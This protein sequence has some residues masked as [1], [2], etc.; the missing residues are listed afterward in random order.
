MRTTDARMSP[1]R[2]LALAPRKPISSFSTSTGTSFN[3]LSDEYPLPKSS[4]STTNPAARSFVTAPI[5][6]SGASMYALSVISRC[7]SSAGTS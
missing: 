6:C 3:V 5:S 1:P 4:I 7:S 2:E